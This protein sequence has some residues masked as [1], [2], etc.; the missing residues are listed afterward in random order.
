MLVF[1]PISS[2]KRR[3]AKLRDRIP[4][5]GIC[6]LPMTPVP[7]SSFSS[8]A[9]QNI[10][11]ENSI[12]KIST[13]QPHT[14]KRTKTLA[15]KVPIG[16][17]PSCTKQIPFSE[18]YQSKASSEKQLHD[19]IH[20]S[21]RSST[22]SILQVS[23]DPASWPTRMSRVREAMAGGSRKAPHLSTKSNGKGFVFLHTVS[24]SIA[25]Q[26]L[27]GGGETCYISCLVV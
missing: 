13:N 15:T 26:L 16:I 17:P 6:S 25:K 27:E 21:Y 3:V 24:A 9:L 23:S 10:G 19:H 11:V 20:K 5:L 12:G 1:S 14:M 2:E 4:G 22:G 8:S 7:A 18:T